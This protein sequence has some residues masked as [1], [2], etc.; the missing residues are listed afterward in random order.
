MR[1]VCCT[2]Y[3]QPFRVLQATLLGQLPPP[4]AREQSPEAPPPPPPGQQR[5][6][7]EQ[8][9]Q[10]QQQAVE[11]EGQQQEQQQQ[12]QQAVDPRRFEQALA[13]V[14]KHKFKH[15]VLPFEAWAKK[16]DPLLQD[17]IKA[18]DAVNAHGQQLQLILSG[19]QRLADALRDAL[20]G[21]DTTAQH[22]VQ[23]ALNS[24]LN[25]DF[26]PPQAA[27]QFSNQGK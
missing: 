3:P 9:Q 25:L 24:I 18:V 11:M 22:D 13:L 12:Q 10:Q 21:T 7:E 4:G 17:V 6:V 19:Q 20:D 16:V 1:G 15:L 26:L 23:T 8:G 5:P 27:A 2:E 14:R